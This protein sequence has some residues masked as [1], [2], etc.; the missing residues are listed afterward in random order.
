MFTKKSLSMV[1]LSGGLVLAGCSA[2]ESVSEDKEK[3][4]PTQEEKSQVENGSNGEEQAPVVELSKGEEL[5]N[6][7]TSTNWQGT[8]VNDAEGNNLTEENSNFIGLAKYDQET[9]RYEFFDKA[10]GETRGDEGIF[11]ITKDGEKRILISQSMGYQAVVDITEITDE[12]FTYKR[13]GVDKDGN[14]VEVFV[15]HVPYTESELEFTNAGPELTSETGEIVKDIPGVNILADTLWNGTKVVDKDGNDVTEFNSNFISIAK[16]DAETSK[17]EFFDVTSGE[18]RGD[19]GYFDVINDNKIRTH[20][21][22][23]E[24]KYGAALEITELNDDRFTYKRMGK[25]ADG[26]DIEIYVEHEPYKGE[27]NPTFGF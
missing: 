12:I 19:F 25:D 24:N 9:N 7:L 1:I 26:N 27:F 14:E 22:I 21:S 8:E 20:V 15:E 4:T 13:M 6:I 11:F 17:Y 3:E 18:S 16:F 10:T 5:S 23:G 2:N